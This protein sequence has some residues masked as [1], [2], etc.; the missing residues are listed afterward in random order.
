MKVFLLTLFAVQTAFA[1]P[2]SQT[3]IPD[4]RVQKHQ[5]FRWDSKVAFTPDKRSTDVAAQTP[6]IDQGVTYGVFDNN[7]VGIEA[8][9]DWWEPQAKDNM[10]SL[11]GHFKVA[12]QES[13]KIPNFALG[14]YNFGFQANTSD[15][16][17]IYVLVAKTFDSVGRFQLGGF[18]GNKNV[19]VTETGAAANDGF[20]FGYARRIPQI[21]EHFNLLFD[22]QSSL[23]QKG[24]LSLGARWDYN[25]DTSFLVGYSTYNNKAIARDVITII[26][27]LWL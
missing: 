13:D 2:T 8:G 11:H 14:V 10:R 26:V 3:W 23:G 9:G 5:R 15:E 17:I 6:F 1:I 19:L 16:N 21:S 4:G 12:I 7:V 27:S 22:Y 18:V 24:A 25:A 20:F